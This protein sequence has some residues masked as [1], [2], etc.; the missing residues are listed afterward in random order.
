M[1]LTADDVVQ[2]RFNPTKFREGYDQDEVDDFLDE[3][4]AELRRL[5][6]ENED[7]RRQLAAATAAERSGGTADG[8]TPTPAA[9]PGAAGTT[10]TA[11]P[12]KTGATVRD[13]TAAT[14]TAPTT[15]AP[16]TTAPATTAPA[17]TAP[18]SASSAAPAA[19]A[20]AASQT[21]TGDVAGMLALAQR[22]HD[23]H[24]QNGEKERDRLVS[25]A[26]ET[27]TTL[28]HDAEEK[29]QQV[30]GSL[31]QERTLLERKIDELR[32]F[33]RDYRSRLK[34]Y[35]ENQLRDL[36]SKGQVVPG[37]TP[38]KPG[39]AGSGGNAAPATG[40]FPLGGKS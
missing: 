12:A 9:V 7:V 5:T 13:A 6:T 29:Q 14:T 24:V 4:V 33:E 22:L 10:D 2:K 19:A 23:E 40:G 20:A 38:G 16:A 15:T 18:A 37:R 27:A 21:G 1:P 31:E 34:S 30:L 35:L 28:V 17:T 3:V 26:K 11:G 25:T 32:G 8:S 39:G 36:D